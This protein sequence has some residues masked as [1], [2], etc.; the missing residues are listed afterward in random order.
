MFKPEPVGHFSDSNSC[1]E[2]NT[3]PVMESGPDLRT[4]ELALK[5][6][7]VT[8]ALC[9]SSSLSDQPIKDP[10]IWVVSVSKT[11]FIC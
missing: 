10:L 3:H 6:P 2:Q 9:T 8:R 5:H 4:V 1:G 11:K 7:V